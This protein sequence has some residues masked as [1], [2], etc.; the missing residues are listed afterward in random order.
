MGRHTILLDV[1]KEARKENKKRKCICVRIWKPFRLR[2]DSAVYENVTIPP[3][4]HSRWTKPL[5]I[6]QKEQMPKQSRIITKCHT[7]NVNYIDGIY[8]RPTQIAGGQGQVSHFVE[9]LVWAPV[10]SVV[11]GSEHHVEAESN[12]QLHCKLYPEANNF[13]INN[14]NETNR[15][16]TTLHQL[17]LPAVRAADNSPNCNPPI[18]RVDSISAGGGWQS[19]V[20]LVSQRPAA[21]SRRQIVGRFGVGVH[22]PGRC[23]WIHRRKKRLDGVDEPFGDPASRSSRFRQLYLC[24]V[25]RK[26]RFSQRLCFTR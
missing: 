23:C 20:R 6:K 16:Q 2:D 9:L 3:I 1:V 12:I 17:S 8:R 13:H 24:T 18:L 26:I 21:D 11:E 25:E 5:E 15:E 14:N 4:T 7:G 19:A 10:A 22:L